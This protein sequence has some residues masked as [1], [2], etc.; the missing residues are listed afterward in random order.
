MALNRPESSPAA[1]CLARSD[2]VGTPAEIPAASTLNRNPCSC[3]FGSIASRSAEADHPCNSA[4]LRKLTLIQRVAML[5]ERRLAKE[6]AQP[7]RPGG[8]GMRHVWPAWTDVRWP[9]PV[10][11]W[12][13][14]GKAFECRAACGTAVTL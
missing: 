8:T 6:A 1:S 13:A 7:A 12:G 11:Q 3:R 10:D 14:A 2:R 9:F 5:L 4:A